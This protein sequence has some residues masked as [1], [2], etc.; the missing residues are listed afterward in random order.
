[1]GTWLG[2]VGS[3]QVGAG[4]VGN[5]P[6]VVEVGVWQMVEVGKRCGPQPGGLMARCARLLGR[7]GGEERAKVG[8]RATFGGGEGEDATAGARTKAEDEGGGGG[9]MLNQ[10]GMLKTLGMLLKMLVKSKGGG[11]GGGG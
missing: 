1:V 7:G 4:V 9:G 3:V 10:L 2:V 11:G 8:A 6:G 5:E